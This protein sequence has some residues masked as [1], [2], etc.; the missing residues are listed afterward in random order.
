LN[1]LRRDKNY[2]WIPRAPRKHPP[3]QSPPLTCLFPRRINWFIWLSLETLDTMFATSSPKASFSADRGTSVSSITSWRTA[4]TMTEIC[5]RNKGP[6]QRTAVSF[7]FQRIL[8]PSML[9]FQRI[10]NPSMLSFQRILNPSMLS[11]QRILTPCS[12][13]T[14]CRTQIAHIISS[15][16]LRLFNDTAQPTYFHTSY[17]FMIIYN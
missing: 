17:A 5:L 7:I 12:I 4:A 11:F 8:N 9:S 16:M 3:L 10:L 6:A 1:I 13:S 14:E 15:A 2:P